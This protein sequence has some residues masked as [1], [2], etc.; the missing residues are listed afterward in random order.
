M[1]YNIQCSTRVGCRNSW[2]EGLFWFLHGDLPRGAMSK[3]LPV[4]PNEFPKLS[5]YA[6]HLVLNLLLSNEV[7]LL[8]E[9]WNQP[10][11][12]SDW[13]D[14]LW[15][16]SQDVKDQLLGH[17]FS[18]ALLQSLIYTFGKKEFWFCLVQNIEFTWFWI[19]KL[20]SWYLIIKFWDETLLV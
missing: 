8:V 12:A 2:L 3:D 20:P 13:W 10:I 5:K 7:C 1:V 9:I 15:W 17:N 18:R 16:A 6:P 11:N 19:N 4:Y 14:Y